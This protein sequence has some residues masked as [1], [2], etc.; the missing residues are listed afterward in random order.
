MAWRRK[1][2][3]VANPSAVATL[4]LVATEEPP[5]WSLE[6][7]SSTRDI[8]HNTAAL[9]PWARFST[10]NVTQISLHEESQCFRCIFHQQQQHPSPAVAVH[11]DNNNCCCCMS[12]V[13]Y[14]AN[15]MLKMK[16]LTVCCMMSSCRIATDY[17][18]RKG[19]CPRSVLASDICYALH[20]HRLAIIVCAGHTHAYYIYLLNCLDPATDQDESQKIPCLV[21]NKK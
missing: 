7:S 10:R 2:A 4:A 5:Q 11:S 3:V 6:A 1:Q 18:I 20:I 21:S 19:K 14:P 16:A 13:E 17:F 12:S 15:A 8:L 9:L